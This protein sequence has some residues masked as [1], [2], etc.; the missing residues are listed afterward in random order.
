MR[1]L[2]GFDK[3]MLQPGE[4]KSVSVR[5]GEEAF[6]FYDPALRKWVVE[7]GM[8]TVLVGSSSADIR[9]KGQLEV[10]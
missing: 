2:K 4:S 9:L 1:V 8:F 5:L 7:P 10:K 3:V 6:R